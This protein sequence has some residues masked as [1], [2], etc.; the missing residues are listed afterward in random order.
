M[1]QVI[2]GIIF[3]Y[4]LLSLFATILNELLASYFAFRGYFLERTIKRMLIPRDRNRGKRPEQ[5]REPVDEEIF[6]E[7]KDNI[8]IQ[9]LRQSKMPGRW[10]TFP[11]Y[12]EDST[13]SQ[14]F[15]N[16]LE[17]KAK[18]DDAFLKANT[19][20][21]AIPENSNLRRLL[22]EVKVRGVDTVEDFAGHVQG[23]YNIM[24]DRASGIYKQHIQVITIVVGFGIAA[25]FN[26][27]TFQIYKNLSSNPAAR[28]EVVGMA[29]KFVANNSTANLQPAQS[30]NI[31]QLNNQLTT[32][33]NEDIERIKNPLGIGWGHN[34]IEQEE[35]EIGVWGWV[36]RLLGWLV[37]AIAIA[38]GAPFW[39]DILR[40]I[41]MVRSPSTVPAPQP[42]VVQPTIVVPS[43]GTIPTSSEVVDRRIDPAG[44]E[45][46]PP[47]SE[48]ENEELN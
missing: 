23:L 46:L 2:I 5:Q 30:A 6:N 28:T 7:F 3:T 13:F 10:S 4:L 12:L 25:A 35:F 17:R 45:P 14:V 39:F 19:L 48:R 42:T 31:Q 16:I 34:D 15:L 32:L 36:Q 24:M 20:I 27:D 26:A 43:N 41:M 33:L 47:H 9:Q 1:L 40:K 18:V 38:L 21:N 29:E 8:I 11:S 22:E 44:I 37:T